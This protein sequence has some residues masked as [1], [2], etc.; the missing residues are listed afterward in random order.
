MR[1]EIHI[2]L[3]N[4]SYT[5]AIYKIVFWDTECLLLTGWVLGKGKQNFLTLPA[6]QI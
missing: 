1:T 2:K 5:I 4:Q 3:V 6:N